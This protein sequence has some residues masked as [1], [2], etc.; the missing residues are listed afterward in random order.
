MQIKEA[1]KNLNNWMKH[2]KYY[3]L[4][5]LKEITMMLVK[6]HN[7]AINLLIHII[8]VLD[9]KLITNNINIIDKIHQGR[10]LTEDINSR[11]DGIIEILDRKQFVICFINNN[12]NLWDKIILEQTEHN[13]SIMTICYTKD[14]HQ[15][16]NFHLVTYKM[17]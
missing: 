16:R 14:H 3:L 4:N 2:I 15:V 7:K 8:Q 12:S 5:Q 11:Q 9:I 17:S 6:V 1:K 10:I 13:N